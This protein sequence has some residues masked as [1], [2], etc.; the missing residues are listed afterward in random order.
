MNN[1]GDVETEMPDDIKNAVMQ[2]QLIEHGKQVLSRLALSQSQQPEIFSPGGAGSHD[3][4]LLEALIG[5][6]LPTISMGSNLAYVADAVRGLFAIASEYHDKAI[7]RPADMMQKLHE[8]NVEKSSMQSEID[9]LRNLVADLEKRLASAKLRVEADRDAIA[10]SGRNVLRLE[11]MKAERLMEIIEN[12]SK[13]LG[14]GCG[15]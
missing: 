11:K 5:L 1:P 2:S 4:K 8:L 10:E 13:A 7:G 14:R 12:L 9:G 6:P 3:H 15:C